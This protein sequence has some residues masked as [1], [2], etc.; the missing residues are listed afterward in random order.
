MEQTL[1]DKILVFM[2]EQDLCE[3][4]TSKE[5]Y[6]V[7]T[8]NEVI[9]KLLADGHSVEEVWGYILSLGEE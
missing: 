3:L 9:V 4:G 1:I 6:P 5:E 7:R 8:V 2:G